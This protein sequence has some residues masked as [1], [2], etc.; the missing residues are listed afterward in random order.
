MIQVNN[1]ILIK[2]KINYLKIDKMIKVLDGY[3][4]LWRKDCTNECF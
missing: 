4:Y 2:C 3:D 1:Y